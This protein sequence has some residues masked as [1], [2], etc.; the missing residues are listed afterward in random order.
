MDRSE[1]KND[2][3]LKNLSSRIISEE[4][5]DIESPKC[6]TIRLMNGEII[7]AEI[8]EEKKNSVWYY[9]CTA[10]KG[11]DTLGVDA[12]LLEEAKDSI[13][14]I[15]Y[16]E[17]ESIEERKK[18]VAKNRIIGGSILFVASGIALGH[19]STNENFQK[20]F[21][22]NEGLTTLLYT[23]LLVTLVGLLI[24]FLG[25]SWKYNWFKKRK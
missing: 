5:R 4:T 2:S 9:K 13:K 17:K 16:D 1:S 15:L 22:K 19:T 3:Y 8:I 6:D 10:V 11:Y 25:L 14:E 23:L 20:E 12:E 7:L 24:I 21:G 18:K